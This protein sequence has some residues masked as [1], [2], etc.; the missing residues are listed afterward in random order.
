MTGYPSHIGALV[1]Y[2]GDT[3]TQTFN[4]LEDGAPIA[5]TA[6]GWG[7]WK[8]QY[9]TS[10]SASLAVDFVVDDS[11]ANSGAITI[12]LS[13]EDTANIRSKGVFDLQASQSGTVRTWIRG[14]L[15]WTQ[16]VTRG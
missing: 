10:P 2:G 15:S 16:D 1:V 6:K 7:S 3:F 13:A 5:L 8:A 11:Q 4:F 12:S 14:E 9:R